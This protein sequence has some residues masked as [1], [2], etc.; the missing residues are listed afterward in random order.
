MTISYYFDLNFISKVK[1][2]NYKNVLF[3]VRE[4]FYQIVF[5]N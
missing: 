2:K 1:N 4:F 5:G 3:S